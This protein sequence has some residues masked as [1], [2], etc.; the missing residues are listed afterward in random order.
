MLKLIKGLLN[1][2]A[3]FD[4]DNDGKIETYREEIQGLFSQ[5][6]IMSEKLDEV[7]VKLQDIVDEE[8]LAQEMEED[9]LKRL[10]EESNK[11]VEESVKRAEKATKEIMENKKSQ[12]K[13][14]YFIS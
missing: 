12:E 8:N 13:V 4:L 11:R 7:N 1:K 5:F 3:K 14:K 10:I 6:K 2:K 9:N